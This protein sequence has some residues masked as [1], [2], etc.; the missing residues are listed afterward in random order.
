MKKWIGNFKAWSGFSTRGVVITIA[1]LITAAILLPAFFVTQAFDV[2][3]VSAQISPL[4]VPAEGYYIVDHRTVEAFEDI[5]PAVIEQIKQM[6]WTHRNKSVGENT[7]RGLFCLGPEGA[8]LPNCYNAP[9][10][11]DGGTTYT[12]D[13]WVYSKWPDSGPNACAG[14][15]VDATEC[16]VTL[17]MSETADLG[18]F[19]FS[20]LEVASGSTITH[21][22]S[23][24]LSLLDQYYAYRGWPKAYWTSSLSRDIGS[25]EATSFNDRLRAH[26]RETGGYLLDFADIESHEV[27]NGQWQACNRVITTTVTNYYP[28]LCQSY[29]DQATAGHLNKRGQIVAAKAVWVFMAILTGWRPGIEPEPSATATATWTPIPPTVS[30]LQTP[31]PTRTPTA[32]ATP[33]VVPT[34]PTVTPSATPSPTPTRTPT[35]TPTPSPTTSPSPTPPISNLV[36]CTVSRTWALA[37]AEILQDWLNDDKH[38]DSFEVEFQ[39]E[40]VLVTRSDVSRLVTENLTCAFLLPR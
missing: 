34:Q 4:P 35:R 28:N 18:T 16:F 7:W 29:T 8:T 20:Y 24:D 27:V 6:R 17:I 32:T 38:R 25:K 10:W 33:I 12:Y 40:R 31:T 13:N 5:P 22:F 15:W 9:G 14:S 26:V 30:P 3:S 37:Q 39:G 21:W 36:G 11:V 2:A 19:Q 1:T 23:T